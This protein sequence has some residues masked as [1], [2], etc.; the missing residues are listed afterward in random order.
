M[1]RCTYFGLEKGRQRRIVISYH[2]PVLSFSGLQPRGYSFRCIGFRNLNV[3]TR[4]FSFSL[5]F[6]FSFFFFVFRD[7]PHK[8]KQIRTVCADP[9]QQAKAEAKLRE[10][11]ESRQLRDLSKAVGFRRVVDEIFKAGK[12]VICHNGLLV[13][14]RRY[15]V[16]LCGVLVFRRGRIAEATAT[17]R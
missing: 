3:Y 2:Y 15:F 8:T 5:F 13:R 7:Q 11:D 4:A 6:S 1:Y 17:Q 10:E 12:P 16:L 9:E 14:R